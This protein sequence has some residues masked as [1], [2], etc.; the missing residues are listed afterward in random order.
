[1]LQ[2]VATH[3]N[4]PAFLLMRA[5]SYRNLVATTPKN[6]LAC[7]RKQDLSGTDWNLVS[8]VILPLQRM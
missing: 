2:D 4:L 6:S 1:M 5:V 8:Q 3:W 7:E